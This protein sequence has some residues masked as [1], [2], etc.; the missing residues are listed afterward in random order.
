MPIP[1]QAGQSG[2]QL[3]LNSQDGRRYDQ[4][5]PFGYA[6]P[7]ED[8]ALLVVLQDA[9]YEGIIAFDVKAPR[10]D[11]PQDIAD[12]LTV[13]SQNLV[14]LWGKALNVDRPT[15]RKLREDRRNAAIAGYLGKCLFGH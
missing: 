14:W 11:E 5:L 13:S 2:L 6:E 10:T 4:D 8:L 15:L 3:N 12:I 7:L 1:T 9:T